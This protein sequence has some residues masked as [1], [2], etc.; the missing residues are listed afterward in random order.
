MRNKLRHHTVI[1]AIF[2]L[3]TIVLLQ[4]MILLRPSCQKDRLENA[5]NSSTI[6][7]FDNE[8][9]AWLYKVNSQFK[10]IGNYPVNQWKVAMFITFDLNRALHYADHI[11]NEFD[12]VKAEDD[13][14][15]YAGFS[16]EMGGQYGILPDTNRMKA[17]EYYEKAARSHNVDAHIGR[18]YYRMRNQEKARY[19]FALAVINHYDHQYERGVRLAGDGN[20]RKDIYE[21]KAFEYICNLVIG[22]PHGLRS[23]FFD[24]RTFI[25]F[26]KEGLHNDNPQEKAIYV[27]AVGILDD[28]FGESGPIIYREPGKNDW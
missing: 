9:D 6:N 4:M 21:R 7:G 17:I 14:Y 5:S 8:V 23:P 2:L 13:R 20:P 26:I 19:H 27:R 11:Y 22:A 18:C 25:L 15:L 12:P 16:Y 24:S 3:T 28:L 1:A 10:P